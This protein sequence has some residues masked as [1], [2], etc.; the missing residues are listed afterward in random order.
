MGTKQTGPGDI[1]TG[2]RIKHIGTAMVSNLVHRVTGE[3][4]RDRN[5]AAYVLEQSDVEALIENWP[6]AP[7][8]AARQTMRQYGPPN[9]GDPVRL[10]WYRNGP[11][12]RTEITADEI[13]HNFPAPHTDFITN[14]IDYDVPIEKFSEL[15][16]YDGSC[17]LDRTAGEAGARCD[18][19]AANMIT[20]NLMHE[21]VTSKRT[22]DEAREKYA[23]QIS[24]YMLGREAKYAERLL[25]EPPRGDTVDLDEAMISSAM[26]EQMGRKAADVASGEQER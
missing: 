10:T 24:A 7:R 14:W 16:R 4:G 17:L 9:L 2:T 13:A 25:F 22:V 21:I 12:K 6:A 15:A 23:E 11:W 18:S 19:E 8:E 3:E 1:S 5:G 20:L 26:A